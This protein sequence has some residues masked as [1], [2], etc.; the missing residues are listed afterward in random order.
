MTTDR[1][2]PSSS[3]PLLEAEFFTREPARRAL[4]GYD[5]GDVFRTVRRAAGLTQEELG[6]LRG[7]DGLDRFFR[8]ERG[9]WRL[10]GIALIRGVASRLG[11]PRCY[12]VLTQI[13][14]TWSGW[15]SLAA[16]WRGPRNETGITSGHAG[17]DEEPVSAAGG[18]D[19]V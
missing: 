13:Q 5:V 14:P 1:T 9:R 10:H 11:I 16:C 8:I 6:D 2:S 3:G 19:A 17:A 12:L 4:A 18:R 15:V 7:L